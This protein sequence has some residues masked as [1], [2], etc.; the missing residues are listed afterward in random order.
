[1][2]KYFIPWRV[3]WNSSSLS[4]PC[5]LVFDASQNTTNGCSLNDLLAK[6]TNNMNKLVEILV[7]WSM[8]A[9]VFHKDI[10]KMCNAIQLDK[11]HWNYQLYLW[12]DT[13]HVK[14]PKWTVIKTLIYGVK[15]SWD[16]AEC[17][18]WRRAKLMEEGHPRESEI[19]HKYIYVDYY[20]SGEN[21]PE[22][23]RT[24][25]VLNRGVF[26]LKGVIGR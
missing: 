24:K 5:R 6:G 8:Y 3:V 16:Q 10:Q 17:G 12:N 9:C 4:I 18:L 7:R 11:S 20:I 2:I 21:C 19:I 1:M 23:G 22:D 26:C 14:E 25:L 13:F 15:S